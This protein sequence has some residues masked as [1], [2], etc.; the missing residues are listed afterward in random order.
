MEV[1]DPTKSW[2]IYSEIVDG[3]GAQYY[4]LEL[5]AGEEIKVLLI[6]PLEYA[7]Q[8][9]LP[10]IAV[11]GMGIEDNGSLPWFVQRP[12]GGGA[13]VRSGILPD[14]LQFEPFSPSAFYEVAV[15]ALTAPTEGTYYLAV[16]DENTGGHY[17]LAIGVRESF[18]V[19]EWLLI[20][21]YAFNIYLWEGQSVLQVVAPSVVVGLITLVGM[22]LLSRRR[23]S[24][25]DLMWLLL[26][27][28][29]SLFM[30]SAAMVLSQT[31]Y[32]TGQSGLEA[33][34]LV[35]VMLT[36]VAAILG[37]A[38]LRIAHHDRAGASITK[39]QRAGLVIIFLLGLLAW[40]GWI[41]GPVLAMIAAVLPGRF[42][43][44]PLTRKR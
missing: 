17:G 24:S 33:T 10:G 41:V 43:L 27:G 32:A 11:M 40:A 35:T 23:H 8:G 20:P 29:G 18:E 7:D 34:A 36:A 26:T 2:A 4:A 28:S 6:V 21:F 22:F 3:G 13:E 9:F 42:L 25:L 14:R 39:K 1:H 12:E 15:I 31:I 38:A 37:T 30:A 5:K 44:Y 19:D 16:F